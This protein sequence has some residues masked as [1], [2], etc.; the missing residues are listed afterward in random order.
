[1]YNIGIRNFAIFFDDLSGEQSGK[2]HANFLNKLQN[3]L[4]QKYQDVYPLMTVPTEYTRNWM[5]DEEGNVK[6]Y[7][8]EFSSLL[9]KNIIV[10]YTGDDGVSDGI[11]EESFQS[12]KDIYNRDL[13]IWWNYPVNDYYL[14]DDNRNIKLALG[15]IEKLPKTKP[16]SI[17]YNPM[18]QPLLSKISI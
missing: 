7:T 16:N 3:A 2:N 15:P 8:Q 5:I 10:L 12:A 17:F 9:N 4:D 1:M 11:S 14:V 13:G 18:K 6:P